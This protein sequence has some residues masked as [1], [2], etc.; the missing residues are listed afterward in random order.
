MYCNVREREMWKKRRTRPVHKMEQASTIRYRHKAR[1]A[2]SN[3]QFTVD[4]QFCAPEVEQSELLLTVESS[5]SAK[6]IG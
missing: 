4:S 3:P 2:D 6:L 5:R 1:A